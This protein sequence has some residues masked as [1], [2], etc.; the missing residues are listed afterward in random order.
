MSMHLEIEKDC[1]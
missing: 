1:L